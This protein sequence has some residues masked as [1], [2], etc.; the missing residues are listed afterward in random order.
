MQVNGS[1]KSAAGL[2]PLLENS[3]LFHGAKFSSQITADSRA[4]VEKFNITF[5]LEDRERLAA[6]R[7]LKGATQ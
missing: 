7:P 4:N 2:V 3:P 5:A 6:A 1:A